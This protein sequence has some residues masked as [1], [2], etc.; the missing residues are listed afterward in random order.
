[1]PVL[2]GCGGNCG[3]VV[4]V[5]LFMVLLFKLEVDKSS[6]EFRLEVAAAAAAAAAAAT[7]AFWLFRA[8]RR[9]AEC[10]ASVVDALK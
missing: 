8:L 10:K 7:A 3:D 4:I 6:V 9:M 1:M 2:F 5:G